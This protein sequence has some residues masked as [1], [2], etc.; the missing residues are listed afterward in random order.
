MA[1]LQRAF[2][3]KIPAPK[4]ANGAILISD[5]ATC[6]YDNEIDKNETLPSKSKHTGM[7]LELL[8]I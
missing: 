2:E 3:A 4:Q 7:S 5:S 8:L 6:R 1:T